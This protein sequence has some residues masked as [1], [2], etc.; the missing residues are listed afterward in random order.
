MQSSKSCVKTSTHLTSS[1]GAFARGYPLAPQTTV[2]HSQITGFF[3]TLVV[4]ARKLLVAKSPQ[5]CVITYY[6][7]NGFICV[8]SEY[9]S[10]HFCQ[11]LNSFLALYAKK[12]RKKCSFVDFGGIGWNNVKKL[13]FWIKT[14]APC[15]VIQKQLWLPTLS[16]Y[17][18]L[19][20]SVMILLQKSWISW[21]TQLSTIITPF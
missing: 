3:V 18:M 21:C 17:Q 5:F 4:A 16:L 15:M 9:F 19:A 10:L 11:S 13:R 6:R 14:A 7:K 8:P 1:N 20:L 2:L 12:R